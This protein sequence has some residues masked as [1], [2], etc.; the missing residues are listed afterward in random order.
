MTVRELVAKFGLNW[1]RSAF[2]AVDKRIDK[3]KTAAMALGTAFAGSKVVQ[4]SRRMVDETAKAGVTLDDLRQRTGIGVEALQELRYAGERS[5]LSINDMDASLQRFNRRLGS[6]ASGNKA[7]AASFAAAG[8]RIRDS[9]GKLKDADTLLMELADSMAAM[10]TD[11]QRAAHAMNLFGDAGLRMA[12]LFRN[13]AAGIQAFRDEAQELGVMSAQAAADA[14]EMVTQQLRLRRAFTA[15]RDQIVGRLLPAMNETIPKILAWMKANRDLIAQRVEQAV[16]A[17]TAAMLV[18]NNVA[19]AVVNVVRWVADAFGGAASAAMKLALFVGILVALFGVK[20]VALGL[21]V[22]LVEDFI[23][24]LQGKDSLL[25]RIAR[26]IRESIVSILAAD[27]DYSN[28]PF[29]A[30]L[31]DVVSVATKAMLALGTVVDLVSGKG[32]SA[33]KQ[34]WED[35]HMEIVRRQAE[36]ESAR[37]SRMRE[38]ELARQ[39]AGGF[40]SAPVVTP[41]PA[42]SAALSS[43]VVNQSVSVQIDG[44]NLSGEELQS[45][46]EQALGN[47]NRRAFT[48]AVPAVAGSGW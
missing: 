19:V 12:P 34:P 47:A 26:A 14:A 11:A 45:R 39:S 3:L 31:R 44:S 17:I 16:K 46:V 28:S 36:G 10:P 27:L 15:L 37:L 30:F 9:A 29:L 4:W 20:A 22:A 35:L 48:A 23:G 33:A 43:P 21:V 32:W 2:D 5:G 41:S 7:M 1:D 24:A 8:V 42:A 38:E 40:M 18:L 6:A 25:D 13:G